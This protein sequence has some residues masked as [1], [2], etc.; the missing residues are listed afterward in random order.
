M[1]IS[2]N[3]T[4]LGDEGKVMLT[5]KQLIAI[6]KTLDPAAVVAFRD[7]DQSENEINSFVRSVESASDILLTDPY[8]RNV[9]RH[10]GK[11]NIVVLQP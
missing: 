3:S 9:L 11:T 2:E 6:L 7:H 8:I 5:V 4:D 10:R 1:R